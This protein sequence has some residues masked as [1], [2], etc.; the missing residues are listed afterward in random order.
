MASHISVRLLVVALVV[1]ALIGAVSTGALSSVSA[2]RDVT[3]SVATDDTSL[4]ALRDGHPNAGLVEQDSD[5]VLTLRFDRHG[6]NGINWNFVTTLGDPSNPASNHAFSIDN[7]GT[8]TRSIDLEYTLAPGAT[9]G[10][11][12][13]RNAVY[14]FHV[15]RG[16]D[17][18]VESTVE[19]SEHSGDRT[20]SIPDVKTTDR[21]YVTIR[22][23]TVG[24]GDAS[25][26]SGTIRISAGE[27]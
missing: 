5:G 6:G 19:I 16:A 20:A 2:E 22:F 8:Q 26:L 23:D 7:D 17:G 25:D 4:L 15:D 18:T 3:I 14:T 21:I 11:T 10:D 24:I 12:S 1:A 9:D 27:T 13:V